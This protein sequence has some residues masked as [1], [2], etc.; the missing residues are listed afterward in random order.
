MDKIWYLAYNGK[1]EGPYSLSDLKKDARITPDHFV[2]KEGF[3]GWKK[4]RDVPELKELFQDQEKTKNDEEPLEGS[5]K[6]PFAQDELVLEMGGPPSVFW[7]FIAVIIIA[8]LLGQ[9]F[10]K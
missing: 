3:D 4:I 5:K 9:L 8:Y 6:G 2:W 7:I 10:W 1:Q